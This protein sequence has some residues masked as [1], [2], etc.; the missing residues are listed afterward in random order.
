M[1][2]AVDVTHRFGSF[3]L[4]ARFVSEGRLTAFF[5]RSGSGKTSLVN[6]IAG[7]VRPDRGRIVLDDTVLVDTQRGLFVPKYRRRVGYVFQEG[8]LFPH[9]TVRQNLLFGQWFTPARERHVSLD[10]VLESARHRPAAGSPPR[11]LVG[12]RKA[13]RC[14][15]PRIAHIAAP[16]PDGRAAGVAR[17]QPQGRD[18]AVHRTVARRGAGADRLRLAF[19]SR[20]RAA[21]D[22]RRGVSGRPHR[23]HRISRP[24]CWDARTCLRHTWLPKPGS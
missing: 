23:R 15:R 8:R 2:L 17:R 20:S 19:A 5:G 22:D 4:E 14:D 7:V 1:S 6:I 16:A 18:S 12:R 11:R 3:L 13:A 24:M 21:G 10:Q 9:L